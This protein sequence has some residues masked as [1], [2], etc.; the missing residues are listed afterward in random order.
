LSTGNIIPKGKFV[1][2]STEHFHTV[3]VSSTVWLVRIRIF[4]PVG[5][6]QGSS[7]YPRPGT[8]NEKTAVESSR[9]YHCLFCTIKLYMN[10]ENM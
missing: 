2:I 10:H 1:K 9:N 5:V 6:V 8:L 7:I 3:S 4:S